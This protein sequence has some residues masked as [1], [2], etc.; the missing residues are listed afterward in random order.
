MIDHCTGGTGKLAEH[1]T[2]FRRG[3]TIG[4]I[5][6][7][8]GLL[9]TEVHGIFESVDMIVHAGDIGSKDIL[10]DLEKIAPVTAVIGNMDSGIMA[11]FLNETETFEFGGFKFHMRHDLSQ[12]AIDPSLS[13][14]DMVITGHTHLPELTF[15]NGVMYLNPG[16]A[17]PE[18]RN[19]P[20]SLA[21]LT[22]QNGKISA[23]HFY[24]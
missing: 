18:R 14:I 1:D 19:K 21:K 10:N 16:S 20:I 22:L 5:S 24:L 3:R 15:R 11:V 13:G 23:M 6:D 12:L 9:R 8:H 4:V 7:T 2:D 17:G